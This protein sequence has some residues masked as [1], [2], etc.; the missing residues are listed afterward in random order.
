M[1]R[2]INC[3]FLLIRSIIRLTD[4]WGGLAAHARWPPPFPPHL[5]ARSHELADYVTTYLQQLHKLQLE[6]KGSSGII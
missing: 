1:S 5:P 6:L 4:G 3:M 2:L